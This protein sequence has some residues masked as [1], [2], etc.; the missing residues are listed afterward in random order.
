MRRSVL[1]VALAAVLPISACA[2]SQ[3]K[4]DA[5]TFQ[6]AAHAVAT[7]GGASTT[8]AK[9]NDRK[10]GSTA[11]TAPATTP[12][13]TQPIAPPAPAP[14]QPPMVNGSLPPYAA[15]DQV[16]VASPEAPD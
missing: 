12:E 4:P 3:A 2:S 5:A 8:V 10:P 1:V 9:A 14:S 13:V 6:Q 15:T 11:S 16:P 7:A